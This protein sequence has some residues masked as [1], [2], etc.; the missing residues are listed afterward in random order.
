MQ[1]KGLWKE[2]GRLLQARGVVAEGWRPQQV[3][4][5]LRNVQD[6]L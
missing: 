4:I 1:A 3:Q 6:L 5:L 2:F